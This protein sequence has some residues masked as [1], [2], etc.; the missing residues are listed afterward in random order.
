M[1]L[2]IAGQVQT[3][4]LASVGVGTTQLL[5]QGRLSESLVGELYG[6]YY[7]L[8]SNGLV[9]QA[10]STPALLN[11]AGTT[12]S[13][14]LFNP[15][16]SGKNLMLIRAQLTVTVVPGTPTAGIFGLYINNNPIAAAVTGTT[17][18]GTNCFLGNGTKPVAFT[19]TTATLPAVPTLVRSLGQKNFAALATVGAGIPPE[20]DFDGDMILGPGTAVSIQESTADTTNSTASIT[21]VWAELPI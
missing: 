3:I 2:Q 20:Y 8:T 19:F 1:A 21:F 5:A 12:A 10:I 15:A 13:M 14:A 7:Q 17:L 6:K 11:T 18:A 16:N 4:P 9:F